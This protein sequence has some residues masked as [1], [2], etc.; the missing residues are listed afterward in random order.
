MS[1][2]MKLREKING[3]IARYD[4]G[5]VE[6]GAELSAM[7][8]ELVA[9]AMLPVRER[10][11]D[12]RQS[13]TFTIRIPRPGDPEGEFQMYVHVGLYPDGRP[14]EL[15]ITTDKEGTFARAALD[16]AATTLSVALQYGA[17]LEPIVQKW[18]GTSFPPAGVTGNPKFPIVS[19]PLDALARLLLIEFTKTEPEGT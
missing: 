3:I 9:V 11:P 4:A 13:R 7:L 18:R 5:K 12:T 19:S 1:D 14:G 17:P 6:R 10:L 15:F 16:A 2:R 8:D